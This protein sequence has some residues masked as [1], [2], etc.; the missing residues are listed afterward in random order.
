MGVHELWSILEPV[1]QHVPLHSLSG[2]T[3]AV[4][5]SLWVCEAQ[6]VKKMIGVVTK[7][8]LRNLFFRVS[9]MNLMGV[10]LVFV[11]EGEAPKVK[12]DTMNKRN[13]M[14]YGTSS[15]PATSRPGRSYFMS[16]LKECLRLLDCLGVPWVQAAG[17]AEAMCAYMN[18][19]GYVDGCITNDGDVF[20]YGAQTV[21]RN[22]TM[23][24]KDPHVDCYEVSS[25]QARLGLHRESLVALA[26]FLGC[27]YLPKG[28]PGVGREQALKLIE[29]LKGENILQR[30]YQWKKQFDDPTMFPKSTKKVV[31][32]TVCRH[33]GSTKDHS[34]NGCSLCG[35]D[36]YCEPHDYDYCCP[37]SWHK[38]EQEK[39]DNPVEYNIKMKAKR[40]QG[41]P[42]HEVIDEFL[43]N[44]NKLIKVIKWVRPN[45]LSF[46]NYTLDRMEWPRHYACEKLLALLT[47]FDM[48]ERRLGRRQETQL[49]AI[50]IV[51][52]RIR[53]GIPCFEIEW[54]TPDSYVFADDHPSDT[55]LVSVEE[56]SLFQAAY[57]EIVTMYHKEKLEEE[58]T[59]KLKS[60]KTKPKS[61]L[62]PD[63]D[64][65]ALLL[66]EMSLKPASEDLSPPN[67]MVGATETLTCPKIAPELCFLSC[68][69]PVAVDS[70]EKTETLLE[71]ETESEVF[72]LGTSDHERNMNESCWSPEQSSIQQLPDNST[73]L[74][75]LISE[76]QL[77]AIDWDSTSFS[78]SPQPES[79]S[80]RMGCSTADDPKTANQP[81]IAAR[82]LNKC[83]QEFT[84]SNVTAPKSK[85]SSEDSQVEYQ[86]LSLKERI[87]LKNAC[88]FS[89]PYPQVP[90]GKP[91]A[92]QIVPLSLHKTES[93][94]SSSNY[95]PTPSVG[96][97]TKVNKQRHEQQ[98][99][100]RQSVL[101]ENKKQTV[102][103]IKPINSIG[104]NTHPLEAPASKSNSFLQDPKKLSLKPTN[105]P[106]AFV[107][108]PKKTSNLPTRN[109]SESSISNKPIIP[110]GPK[111][112]MKKSVCQ[113]VVFSSE[114]SDT[115]ESTDKRHKSKSKNKTSNILNNHNPKV[116]KSKRVPPVSK[117]GLA[118]DN[119]MKVSLPISSI[120]RSANVEHVLHRPED[121]TPSKTTGE[122]SDG[123]DSIVSID[124]PL[125]LAERL[126]L[127]SLQNC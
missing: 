113:Q 95:V 41:F 37:C 76:L 90:T 43:R 88:Q 53:N 35:S 24:V 38:A 68:D 49:Q 65:V 89:V 20:L 50:R 1:K 47:Y 94:E 86:K 8:H 69:S 66:S 127:R 96:D 109:L 60:K 79:Q 115:E 101:E 72:T 121:K 107:K 91:F 98:M 11:T 111:L 46:Q 48:N 67:S 17:E 51:K 44:K 30:F 106:Y 23:N 9:S 59:K 36:Q 13:E 83:L 80:S 32:C 14:R 18:A 19:K 103:A 34:R 22:F 28:V 124:S 16:V 122:D 64:D 74:S 71:S 85:T 26:I 84:E 78:K 40:C 81:K 63:L 123:D 12:A 108:D 77:S 56:E 97:C 42:F 104:T 100:P 120:V 25:I 31:H 105:R 6:T 126:R 10:K 57:P 62:T 93:V 125:P 29:T 61:K 27:D 54:V 119:H 45:L 33:P 117:V 3:L 7:P 114:D 2:K 116:E 118:M 102:T 110:V 112:A 75:S 99:V 5:L 4:D 58:E 52:T 73:N 39:R 15:K 55:P 87:L 92:M 21:Y 82:N 70:T